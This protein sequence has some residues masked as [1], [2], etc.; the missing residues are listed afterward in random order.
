MHKTDFFTDLNAANT[1]QI[2]ESRALD[3]G[4]ENGV[5]TVPFPTTSETANRL[6]IF[7][8]TARCEVPADGDG[9]LSRGVS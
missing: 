9:E 5:Q 8:G 1:D 6:M 7:T 4:I 3:I 2:I